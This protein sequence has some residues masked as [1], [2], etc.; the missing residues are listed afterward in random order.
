MSLVQILAEGVTATL[1]GL[2]NANT[3]S[4]K[5]YIVTDGNHGLG[6]ETARHL[7]GSSTARVILTVRNMKAGEK[8][9][10]DIESSTGRIGIIELWHL[11]LSSFKSV[12]D[13]ANKVS[14]ELERIDAFVANAGVS[15]D[16]WEIA[17][18]VELSMT[19]IVVNTMFLSVLIMPKLV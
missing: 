2:V 16:S 10:A 6:L 13:F 19:V 17:E 4:G 14:A 9:K 12:K 8:A 18:G 5:T 11:D 1:P 3:C 15:M 7:V